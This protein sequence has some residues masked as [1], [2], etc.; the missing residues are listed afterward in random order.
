MKNKLILLIV[1]AAI[2]FVWMR[3]SGG[4]APLAD[5]AY[6][7]YRQ[8]QTTVR[9]TFHEADGG[10]YRTV[11]EVADGAGRSE[12]SEHTPGHDE[13]VDGRMRT[14]SGAIFELASFGR[15]P[16]PYARIGRGTTTW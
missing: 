11:V 10:S 14:A 6:L 7:Q 12:V 3:S 13:T 4:S 8:E 2:V 15:T 9:L 16:R 1:A 5:G